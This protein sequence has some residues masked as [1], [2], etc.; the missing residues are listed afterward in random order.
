MDKI[1]INKLI[2]ENLN[3]SFDSKALELFNEWLV[4]NQELVVSFYN[5]PK[6]KLLSNYAVMLWFDEFSYENSKTSIRKAQKESKLPLNQKKQRNIRWLVD[7]MKE[8]MGNDTGMSAKQIHINIEEKCK[9]EGSKPRYSCKPDKNGKTS[10]SRHIDDL[11]PYIRHLIRTK[12]T[13]KDM[14]S[15]NMLLR[16]ATPINES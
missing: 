6:E 16:Y 4:T 14:P 15:Q 5:M 9:K 12:N 1:D 2:I 11:L 8:A 13:S 10:L 7:N 3:R